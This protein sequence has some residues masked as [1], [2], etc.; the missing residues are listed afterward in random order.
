MTRRRNLQVALAE[1]VLSTALGK[2]QDLM[3]RPPNW[4][5]RT[6]MSHGVVRG[7][8]PLVDTDDETGSE[9]RLSL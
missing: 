5:D 4:D 9:S 7:P 6:P 1:V 2:P 8:G 3:D